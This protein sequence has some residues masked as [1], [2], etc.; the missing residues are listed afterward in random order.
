MN[1]SVIPMIGSSPIVIDIFWICWN[2]KTAIIPPIIYLSV[3]SVVFD[4][5]VIKLISKNIIKLIS[6]RAPIN[7]KHELN[8]VNMKSV[9]ISGKYIGTEF[10]PCPNNPAE[11]IAIKELDNCIP[12]LLDQFNILSIL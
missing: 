7:P 6:N 4:T 2:N 1:G 5:I 12:L 10:N 9:C 8:T 11:P 3:V